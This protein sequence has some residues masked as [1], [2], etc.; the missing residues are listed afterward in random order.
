MAVGKI[1]RIHEAVLRAMNGDYAAQLDC[2]GMDDEL[3]ALWQSIVR[4]I[5]KLGEVGEQQA[6][7][8]AEL[9][10]LS[11]DS[12]WQSKELD[13]RNEEL[14]EYAKL[15]QKR[16]A[17]AEEH[18]AQLEK[19]N[20]KLKNESARVSRL[21]AEAK[22]AS[23]AKSQFLANMSHEIRTPLNGIIGMTALALDTD[24]SDEQKD[25]LEIVRSSGNDLLSLINDILDFSKIEAGQLEIDST[26]FSLRTAMTSAAQTVVVKAQQKGLELVCDTAPD[27]PDVLVGDPGRL[28]QIITNLAGN[29]VK[30]TETG[31]VLIGVEC[32]C[33][34]DTE[35]RLRFSVRDTGIGIPKVRQQ[36]I[37]EPFT[38]VDGSTTRKFGGTGLGLSI[39]RQLVELMGGQLT[40]ESEEGVGSVFSFT[41][42]LGVQSGQAALP[43]LPVELHGMPVLVVDDNSTNR[44]MLTTILS[45]WGMDVRQSVDGWQ[46]LDELAQAA[47][48]GRPYKLL[49]LDG[50]MPGLD[51]FD[52]AEQIRRRLNLVDLTI[53][54]LTS[55]GQRGDVARCGRLGISAYLTKPISQSDLLDAVAASLD[56]A[57][58]AVNEKSVV[59]RR[60]LAE[61]HRSLRVLL[62]EDNLVNQKLAAR[63]LEKQ[64][65]TVAV[66]GNGREAIEALDDGTF[67]LV[68][69]DVQMPEMDGLVATAVIRRRE[70][71]TGR[72]IPI[73][74]MTA[75]AMTGDR[76][77]CLE[78][79]MDGYVSKPIDPK[80]LFEAMDELAGQER[81]ATCG[82]DQ[83]VGQAIGC[84]GMGAV[85]DH[86]FCL[87]EA[88][89]RTGEDA[90]LL[91]EMAELFIEDTPTLLAVMEQA[92]ADEDAEGVACAAHTLKGSVSNFAA[93]EATLAA[94][95]VETAGRE[96]DLAEAAKAFEV[97][98]EHT[99]RLASALSKL[100]RKRVGAG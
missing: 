82:V 74:A 52:V 44:R 54:M 48:A 58:A 33:Q 96:G 10:K 67:D 8:Q 53:L 4:M 41:I 94:L 92:L 38:Q 65:H 100:N 42:D 28:K 98:K 83:A 16:K 3:A 20:I 50:C 79:G 51:G 34:T 43:A 32:L 69:M 89:E 84:Q 86:P 19:L 47:A 13:A 66:A 95:N 1:R 31:E 56:M 37:L 81:L 60:S 35:A 75:H 97:L 25:Y 68:L 91:R 5:E 61:S 49:L 76:E 85:R 62:A 27:A 21:A 40:V 24:L 87:A 36:A 63:I 77:R 73:I 64:G 46:A 9:K 30:F 71:G 55:A 26:D 2:A 22:Q 45:H 90:Q 72:H 57:Q 15:L 99:A 14:G 59:T 70:A 39:S 11:D 23:L 93:K 12:D 78:A 18:S 7:A 88:L 29:A 17:E 6:R 80:K